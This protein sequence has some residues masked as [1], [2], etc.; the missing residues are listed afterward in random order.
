MD[1]QK[2]DIVIPLTKSK[3]DFLDLKYCL[4]GIEKFVKNYRNIVIIGEKPKWIKNVIHI[5]FHEIL[6]DVHKERNILD[7]FLISCKN[8]EISSNFIAYN[9][10]YVNLREISIEKYPNFYKGELSD[11]LNCDNTYR[12]TIRHTIEYLE[13]SDKKTFNY[14]THCPIIYNKQKFLSTFEPV[15]FNIPFGYGIKS[16]YAN[17]NDIEGEFMPDMKFTGRN[18]K[19]EVAEI[20]KERHIISCNE[21][22]LRYGL[23]DY[24]KELFKTKSI[25]E[26]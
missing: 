19:Q 4:R 10:D 15:D 12:H 21:T 13:K 9:D 1:E 24:L 14:D 5:P 23:G 3:I 18:T 6:S 2:L 25:F 22:A 26:C 7:K 16:M 20:C 17:I 11:L 8:S